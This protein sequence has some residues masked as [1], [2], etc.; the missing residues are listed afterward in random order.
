[1]T[2]ISDVGAW[3][4]VAPFSVLFLGWL[5][6]KRRPR[7]ALFFVLSMMGAWGLEH[8][9]KAVF[10]RHRPSLWISSAPE[11]WFGFPSGHALAATAL[12]TAL[13]VLA[14]PTRL[15][16]WVA[17]GSAC[18]VLL[19]SAARLYLGVHYPSDVLAG[20]LASLAW[21]LT[22]RRLLLPDRRTIPSGAAGAGQVNQ[23]GG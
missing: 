21:V 13:T 5:L 22:L 10:A 1:M 14:W 9:G 12:A 4:G 17:A 16:W 20:W 6:W 2:G 8:A 18:F 11:R 7:S 19:V 3:F 23:S 15:R